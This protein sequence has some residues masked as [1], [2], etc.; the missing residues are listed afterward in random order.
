MRAK[1]P[2]RE[3]KIMSRVKHKGDRRVRGCDHSAQSTLPRINQTTEHHETY[4]E[5]ATE[6]RGSDKIQNKREKK[7]ILITS[8]EKGRGNRKDNI[9]ELLLWH[10]NSL[11]LLWWKEDRSRGL[12]YPSSKTTT[13]AL[14][15]LHLLPTMVK[16]LT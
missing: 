11:E 4:Q 8:K 1:S 9:R 14:P 15:P 5:F 7:S 6:R 10:Q 16:P 2:V 3:I 13:Y 12:R